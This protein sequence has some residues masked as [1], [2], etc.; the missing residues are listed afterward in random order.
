[1][2]SRA[3]KGI[4]WIAVVFVV[5]II[6]AV[7]YVAFTLSSGPLSVGFLKETVRERVSNSI[8]GIKLELDDVV[9]ERV[10]GSG[11][12]TL[13]LA[14]VRITDNNGNMLARAPRA[15]IS[16]DIGKILSGEVK[17]KRL[18]L[19]GARIL[20]RRDKDGTIGMG[21]SDAGSVT[22]GKSDASASA[23]TQTEAGSDENG[24]AKSVI[25]TIN[26]VLHGQADSGGAGSLESIEITEAQISFKDEI[27][28]QLW[29]SPRANLKFKRADGGFALFMD[30]DISADGPTWQTEVLTTY[31]TDAK[32]FRVVARV[33]GVTPVDVARKMFSF[34]ELANIDLPMSGEVQLDVSDKGVI[35]KAGGVLALKAGKVS[36]PG[37]IADPVL[38][39]EG[40]LRLAYE[41]QTGHMV[42]NDSTVVIRGA[43]A[44]FRGRVAPVRDE[45]HKVVAARIELDAR[46]LNIDTPNAGDGG[47]KID[48]FKLRGQAMLDERRFIVDDLIVLSSDGGVRVRGQFVGEGNSVGV[49][50]AGRGKSLDHALIRK[51]W[52]PVLA[53]QSR[54]WYR[55][56]VLDGV[57][58]DAEFRVRVSGEQIEQAL[59]NQPLPADAVDLKFSA[60]GVG[61]TYADNLPPVKNSTG[62]FHVSG[63]V[64][65]FNFQSGSMSLPSGNVLKIRDGSMQITKL[66]LPISP[67]TLNIRL[68]GDVATFAEYANLPALGLLE[69]SNF[70]INSVTGQGAVD[71][72][73]AM[74]LKPGITSSDFA[75]SATAK[76][77]DG[78]I[79]NAVHGLDL[80]NA[81][82]DLTLSDT[83]ISGKGTAK[84]GE[85][86]ATLT[87]KRP[88][89]KSA[90]ADEDMTI[91][92]TLSDSDR[93]KLGIDLAP[94]L[95]GPVP[96]KVFMVRRGEEIVSASV[97][98]DLAKTAMSL[99][100]LGWSRS[101]T[102]KTRAKF[103]VNMND[104]K[105]IKIS[106]LSVTGRGLKIIGDI[107]VSKAGGGL[108]S[109]SF[110]R[111]I[112]SD[113]N[114]LALEVD[115]S[116][117]HLKLGV[118]GASLDARPLISRMM[119][120]KVASRASKKEPPV[121]INTNI[122]RI[123]VHRGETINNI[124]G[125]LVTANGVVESANV[126][127][128][129][130][131]GA[132]ITMR[133]KRDQGGLR[134]MRVT[135]RDAGATMRA[136]NLYSKISGGTIDF[137]AILG[138]PGQGAI[139]RGLLEIRNFTVQN[140][141]ALTQIDSTTRRAGRG[142]G[143]RRNGGLRLSRLSV[144]FSVDNRFVRIGDALVQGPD[145]GASAQGIIRKN[146]LAMDIGGTIIPAYAL[147]SAIS[148]V[149]V[150]GDVLTG[151]KGQGVFGLNFA[152][153][154]SM[155]QPRFLV[156]PVSAI[157]PGIFRNLFN[158][159]GG[160]TNADGTARGTRQQ[161][162]LPSVEGQRR[163]RKQKL[164]SIK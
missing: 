35:L 55:E 66:A 56:N 25:E 57:V 49:Y 151:G 20:A 17:P 139:Q 153:K 141:A 85:K 158:I 39:D 129:Y 68:D 109:A 8:P 90:N 115:N 143:P 43:E 103:K 135:G 105:V 121:S 113:T 24:S 89:S 104:A 51:L 127:G 99:D 37:Y 16:V 101:P 146:D 30:A 5:M 106:D 162:G 42:I 94:F 80:E 79:K 65:D 61:L 74:P 156:N 72:N 87:W 53:K 73:L 19:I 6:A 108:V 40:Q 81:N 122:S 150:L 149:P 144:P 140:E 148:N 137:G 36:F 120:S 163:V 124:T 44:R 118:G 126:T 70:D 96:V 154:G 54:K 64:F 110:P 86:K 161:P 41:P 59:N 21:F 107:T 93:Q 157:A 7:A 102:A 28:D 147:N 3:L 31:R 33:N 46:D 58:D 10:S 15:A 97:D 45:Q 4:A 26:A 75:V 27:Q 29:V 9:I 125:Q 92:T 83:V 155:N 84:L 142:S 47:S 160:Q 1:L 130:V 76:L 95:V 132:P 48:E 63:T 82:F 50:I 23:G 77:Q 62:K 13:R 100:A 34:N 88:L 91:S 67:A 136:V 131:N 145:I 14:N 159:G 60:S 164:Q 128:S 18:E 78:R 11:H 52:P 32:V 71:L 22:S 138:N 112:L 117:G 116:S 123:Y 2:A 152:L 133:I 119:S 69:G 38:I 98:A 134:R 111:F 12:P 114:Q